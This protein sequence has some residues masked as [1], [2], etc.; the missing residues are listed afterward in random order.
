VQLCVNFNRVKSG[1]TKIQRLDAPVHLIIPDKEKRMT[2]TDRSTLVG[3]FEDQA[4]AERALDELHQAGFSNEQVGFAVRN[5]TVREGAEP[6]TATA[7]AAATG[8]VSGGVIGGLVSAAV[9]LLIPGFGPAIAGGILVAT[10]SGIALGAVAGGF[11]GALIALGVPEEEAYYYQREFEAGRII[12]TVR[13]GDRVKDALD[14]LRRNGA[15]EANS[16]FGQPVDPDSIASSSVEDEVTRKYAKP[17][18]PAEPDPNADSF[19]EQPVR[20]GTDEPAEPDNL[21]F[22]RP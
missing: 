5:G 17:P 2:T 15:L 21:N 20:P 14:I 10:L 7:P 18:Q 11:L 4:F 12:I 9:T 16:R 1:V 3:V 8:A 13:A 22:P 6:E 19:F